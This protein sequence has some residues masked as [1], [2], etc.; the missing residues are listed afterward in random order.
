VKVIGEDGG[1][2]KETKCRIESDNDKDVGD[3]EQSELKMA[4]EKWQHDGPMKD[5]PKRLL[6]KEKQQ[7]IERDMSWWHR[8]TV[9]DNPGSR[10]RTRC[11]RQEWMLQPERARRVD[12]KRVLNDGKRWENN[13]DM[14]M[15]IWSREDEEGN[16]DKGI[17]R[18][19]GIGS[20]RSL[21][22]WKAIIE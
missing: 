12:I 21:A 7:R 17:P 18:Q 4:K 10:A 22:R 19:Q 13:W 6:D 16:N 5:N 20:G 14:M 11:R 3:S 1:R 9:D 8:K 2:M 15:S